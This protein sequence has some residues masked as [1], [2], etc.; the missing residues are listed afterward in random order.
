MDQKLLLVAEFP[1]VCSMM[2]VNFLVISV[3]YFH[4]LV[5]V[6]SPL[7]E[8]LALDGQVYWFKFG[9]RNQEVK[10]RFKFLFE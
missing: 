1:G 2:A 5:N 7:W 4:T 3:V 9:L 10:C 8:Y 6:W